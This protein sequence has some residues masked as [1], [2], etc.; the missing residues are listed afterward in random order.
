MAITVLFFVIS[1]VQMWATYYFQNSMGVPP[2]RAIMC[3][4]IVALTS[5]VSGAIVSGYIIDWLGGFYSPAALPFCVTIGVFGTASAWVVPFCNNYIYCIVF[6]WILL[7]VGAMVLPICTGVAFT[8]VEPETRARAMSL[9]NF[10]YNFFGYFPAPTVYGF[11]VYLHGK[12]NSGWGMAALMYFSTFMVI[13]VFIAWIVDPRTDLNNIFNFKIE[14]DDHLEESMRTVRTAED[15]NNKD[16]AQ[17]LQNSQML[18]FNMG[19]GIADTFA[20]NEIFDNASNKP[21]FNATSVKDQAEKIELIDHDE[22]NTRIRASQKGVGRSRV[23]SYKSRSS[24][25]ADLQFMARQVAASGVSD[26][27]QQNSADEN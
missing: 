23:Q 17:D 19:L 24:S 12:S 1:G 20:K 5:P 27:K 9:A 13:F 11:A 22:L 25:L 6:L 10:S 7:F 3:F 8:K 18:T 2:E 21:S 4:A 14:V 16:K 15:D 26:E